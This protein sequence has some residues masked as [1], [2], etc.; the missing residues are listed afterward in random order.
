MFRPPTR[1]FVK[2]FHP[3]LLDSE[4]APVF[5]DEEGGSD[6]FSSPAKGSHCG[7]EGD[8]QCAAPVFQLT[9]EP[10]KAMCEGEGEIRGAEDIDTGLG[11]RK[12]EGN[13]MKKAKKANSV[14]FEKSA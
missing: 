3:P 13:V 8:E 4:A 2:E 14:F 12:H 9:K 7:D 11:T 1:I 5:K 10:L 6:D